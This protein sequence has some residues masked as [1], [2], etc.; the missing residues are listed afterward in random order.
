MW[1]WAMW[2]WAAAW[3]TEPGDEC[4]RTTIGKLAS[5]P[6][7]AVVVLGERKGTMPD[8]GR[9][10]KIVRRLAKKGPVTLA[11]QA[12]PTEHQDILDRYSR[13]EL[14]IEALPTELD[15][16]NR[17]GFP[18]EAYSSLLETK[19]VGAKLVGIGV[20]YAPPP[21]DAPLP[22]PPG[23]IH[24]LA[25]PMG[26]APMPVE[27]EGRYAA[28]VAAMDNR[29]AS[30]AISA[31]NGQGALVIVV[32]R[33]HVEGGQGVQWQARQLTE[34]PVVAALLANAGT[35]CFAGDAVLP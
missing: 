21:K 35:L 32:D 27:L 9:A 8:L 16:E 2:T 23:Y 24:V 26:E 12:I 10:R 29:L 17:W 1:Y 11:L 6:L 20:P 14:A 19:L 31:W 22:Q 34:V 4:T 18:F 33:Y 13:G 3:A 28:F 15:W 5:S 7:P 30:S 25:G